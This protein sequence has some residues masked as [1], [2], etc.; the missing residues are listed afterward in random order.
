[1][2]PRDGVTG[3]GARIETHITTESLDREVLAQTELPEG[4]TAGALRMAFATNPGGD[5]ADELAEAIQ[6][7]I[8]PPDN[9][10][11]RMSF[12]YVAPWSL[13]IIVVF[14]LLYIRDRAKGGYKVETIGEP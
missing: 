2:R 7:F 10:G 12:R 11:G 5:A 13:V 6:V 1:M 3:G 14:G 8:N 4:D 9:Y